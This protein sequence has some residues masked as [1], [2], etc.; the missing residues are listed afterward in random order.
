[1]TVPGRP[2]QVAL[3]FQQASQDLT[4]PD[5]K[6]CGSAASRQLTKRLAAASIH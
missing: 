5:V 6:K 1:L 4:Y 2:G 3:S